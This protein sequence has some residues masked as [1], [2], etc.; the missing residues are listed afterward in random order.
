MKVLYHLLKLTT[1]IQSAIFKIIYPWEIK[2]HTTSILKR[3]FN[4]GQYVKL[5][6]LKVFQTK[7]L[8]RKYI[9]VK[10]AQKD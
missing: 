9:N 1:K 4:D 2:S 6:Q 8:Q 3:Q 7:S 5:H 10:K